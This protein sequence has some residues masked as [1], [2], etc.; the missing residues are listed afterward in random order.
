M[1]RLITLS[2][3]ALA[4]ERLPGADDGVHFSSAMVRT[5]LEEFSAPGERVLDPFAGFGTTLVVAERLGR[6]A[7]GVELLPERVATI[8]ER[9]GPDVRVIEGDARRLADFGIGPVDLCLTSPPYMTAV[10]HPQNPLTGY[11]TLDADYDAYVATLGEIFAVVA[12]LLR[13]GGSLVIN[14][15]NIWGEGGVT[16][17]AW[18]VGRAV[19][20]RVPFV[21]EIYVEWEPPLEYFT[22]D[23]C[24][25]FRKPFGA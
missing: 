10:G 6:S 21:G 25:V 14:V 16:P 2:S 3:A 17:L 18:D 13:P 1:I 8:R 4:D 15:A 5:I 9:V 12:E 24:L 20:A 23:Y 19:A 11:L 7:V 22:G